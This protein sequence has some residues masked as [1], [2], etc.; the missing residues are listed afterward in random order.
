MNKSVLTVMLVAAGMVLAPALAASA[1]SLQSSRSCP[2][3]RTVSTSSYTGDGQIMHDHGGESYKFFHNT[4]GMQW[5]YYN[6]SKQ[7]V[8]YI[9]DYD[10]GAFTSWG[11]SCET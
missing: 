2:A 7:S 11:S 3:G 9:L 10:S 8:T 4:S 1:D 6:G 5:R